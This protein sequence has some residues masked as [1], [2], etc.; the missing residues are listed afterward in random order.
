[1]PCLAHNGGQHDLQA[2]VA[3]QYSEIVSSQRTPSDRNST[4]ANDEHIQQPWQRQTEPRGVIQ[5]T[6]TKEIL[7]RVNAGHSGS[8]TAESGQRLAAS[9]QGLSHQ[10]H[11]AQTYAWPESASLSI[12]HLGGIAPERPALRRILL[13]SIP[14]KVTG[15]LLSLCWLLYNRRVTNPP[16]PTSP[17]QENSSGSYQETQTIHVCQRWEAQPIEREPQNEGTGKTVT[18]CP[19]CTRLLGRKSLV[20]HQKLGKLYA[21]VLDSKVDFG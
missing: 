4:E 8:S 5:P 6:A 7:T 2:S 11:A 13:P 16:N 3:G 19:N 10:L 18:T 14:L 20:E 21:R 1:M 9:H 17:S 12:S 15:S